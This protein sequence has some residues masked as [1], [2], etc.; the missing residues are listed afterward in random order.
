M[1]PLISGTETNCP[2][3]I[4]L[5][6]NRI[7]IGTTLDLEA[8]KEEELTTL[9]S[10]GSG[11]FPQMLSLVVCKR[12]YVP[13]S[14]SRSTVFFSLQKI[15]QIKSARINVD[16]ITGLSSVFRDS[17]ALNLRVLREDTSL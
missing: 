6:L 13:D 14:K 8:V 10:K 4:G 1:L 5:I 12:L 7:Q 16:I 17:H 3:I 11:A 9:P 15:I 2:I